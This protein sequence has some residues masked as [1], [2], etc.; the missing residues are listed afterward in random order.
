MTAT[1]AAPPV[2]LPRA[3]LRPDARDLA[4]CARV[5]LL[6]VVTIVMA[7]IVPVVPAVIVPM[8]FDPGA[9]Q[10]DAQEAGPALAHALDGGRDRLT[11]HHLRADH[12]DY[13][14]GQRSEDQRFGHRP[15]GGRIDHDP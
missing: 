5:G 12:D 7:V 14:I 4:T 10:D 6:A 9:I 11:R 13:A 2:E 3:P 1:S 8:A 15:D